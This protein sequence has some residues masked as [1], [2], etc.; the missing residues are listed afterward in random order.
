MN[1]TERLTALSRVGLVAGLAAVIAATAVGCSKKDSAAPD[2]SSPP[3][4]TT[5]VTVNGTT[6]TREEEGVTRYG[7]EGPESGT[8][9]TKRAVTLHKSADQGSDVVGRVGPGTGVNKKARHGAYYLVDWP[10]PTGMKPGWLLQDDINGTP[11]VIPTV[12]TPPTTTVPPPATPPGVGGAPGGRPPQV[13]IRH[14]GHF[15]LGPP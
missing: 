7:D 10:T 11:N 5:N 4:S 8:V 13:K 12:T 6:A 15:P 14:L 9:L 1:R 3:G 2:G